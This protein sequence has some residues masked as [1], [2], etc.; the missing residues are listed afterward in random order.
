VH[1]QI[2]WALF[3]AEEAKFSGTIAWRGVVPMSSLP[4]HMA[5]VVGT[6]WVGPGGHVVHYPLHR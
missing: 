2:R 6:N 4:R 5:G 1:S 3:G